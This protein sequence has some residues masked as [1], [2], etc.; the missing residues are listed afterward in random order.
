MLVA[1]G[2][3]AADDDDGDGNCTISLECYTAEPLKNPLFVTHADHDLSAY[4]DQPARLKP[5]SQGLFKRN[6]YAYLQQ[7][8]P[9]ILS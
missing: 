2:G 9:N 5:F 1:D 7:H 3:G 4:H 6:S 8:A